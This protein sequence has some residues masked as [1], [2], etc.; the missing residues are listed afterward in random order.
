MDIDLKPRHLR[1]HGSGSGK[2]LMQPLYGAANQPGDNIAAAAARDPDAGA[3]ADVVNGR[4]TAFRCHIVHVRHRAGTF[5]TKDA[6]ERTIL[7][8]RSENGPE[9]MSDSAGRCG[10]IHTVQLAVTERNR[11]TDEDDGRRLAAVLQEANLTDVMNPHEYSSRPSA[12]PR[13][14]RL[15]TVGR[16]AQYA[17]TNAATTSAQPQQCFSTPYT[18][19]SLVH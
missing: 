15:P 4:Q 14:E 5:S 3:I 7:I 12:M 2:Q 11:Q 8:T 18:E 16:S 6:D 9:Q 10:S 13:L 1:G 19:C 17:A